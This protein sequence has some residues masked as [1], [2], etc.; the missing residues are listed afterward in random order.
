MNPKGKRTSILGNLAERLSAEMADEEV[1]PLKQPGAR[2][3]AAPSQLMHFSADFQRNAQ[4]LEELKKSQA[5]G[6]T[7]GLN[8]L[9]RSPFQLRQLDSAR[10]Q[11]LTE[12]LRSNP[13]TTPVVVRATKEEGVF[14]LVAGHHRV[15]AFRLLDRTEIQAVL[16]ELTDDEAERLVFY[17]NLLAPSLSDYEKYLG[18][19][20]R[21]KS[22]GL[23]QEALAAEA[24]IDQSQVSALFSFEKLPQ[25][26]Q[27]LIAESPRLASA[28]L[29]RSLA[30]LSSTHEERVVEAVRRVL[31]EQ[32]AVTAAVDFVKAASRVA[33]TAPKVEKTVVRRGKKVFV[34][35]R[36]RGGQVTLNFAD[37]ADASSTIEALESLLRER[38]NQP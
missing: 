5:K 19:A 3:M 20:Q 23:S 29:F 28:R 26:A 34:E 37:E 2:P 9:R 15:E 35:V 6:F 10:V 7:V 36:R 4:E 21:R 8:Q 22:K 31:S 25:Q 12:N 1:A 18:F 16:Q 17:D 14:E 38:A 33:P 30:P 32:L 24:G 27:A 13:L 11:A